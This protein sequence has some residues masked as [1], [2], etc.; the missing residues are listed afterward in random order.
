[1]KRARI[2][3]SLVFTMLM[4]IPLVSGQDSANVIEPQ[5]QDM[6]NPAAQISFPPPVYVVRDSVDIRGTVTMPTMRNFFIEF[7]PLELDM[8]MSTDEEA[9]DNQWFPATL[10]RIEPVEDDVLGTWNTVTLRD[11]LYEIR[12][13]INTGGEMPEYVRVSPIRVE[14]NPPEFVAEQQMMAEEEEAEPTVDPEPVATPDPSPR[15]VAIVSSNVR[16]GDSTGY[17]VIG[18]LLIDE[19]AKIRGIS[20]FRSGWFYIELANGRTGFIHPNLVQ[21]EGDLT[22]LPRINPPPLPPTAIPIPTVPPVVVQPVAQTNVNLRITKVVI[23]PHPAKCGEAYRI[24]VT[25]QNNGTAQSDRGGIIEVKDSHADSGTLVERTVIGFGALPAGASQTYFGHIT[26]STY[27]KEMHHINLYLD[28]NNEVAE[29][30]EGDN[31]SAAAAYVL[32]KGNCG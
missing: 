15:V 25:V 8:D 12:L 11:G 6:M 26:A 10:P 16:A 21:I 19:T 24:D 2:L 3:T 7:R 1:M 28:A 30:N 22:N 18:H 14:N 27:Y 9:L 4:M 13:T 29:N 17:A 23:S 5:D 31:H 20:A 32:K